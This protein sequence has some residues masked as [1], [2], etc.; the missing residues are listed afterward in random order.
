MKRFIDRKM[1][2]EIPDPMAPKS[3]VEQLGI[4]PWEYRSVFGPR[5]ADLSPFGADGWE[6]VTVIPQPGDQAVFYFRRLKK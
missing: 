3:A 4:S 6:L 5:L 1:V 2:R